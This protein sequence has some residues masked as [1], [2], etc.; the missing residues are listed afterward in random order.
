ML[1]LCP[2]KQIKSAISYPS[3]LR[4]HADSRLGRVAEETLRRKGVSVALLMNLYNNR[5]ESGLQR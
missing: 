1:D 2:Y 5:G 3:R 4:A